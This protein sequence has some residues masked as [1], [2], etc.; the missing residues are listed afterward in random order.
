MKREYNRNASVLKSVLAG[1][2]CAVALGLA[3]AAM[4]QT[5]DFNV[6]AGDLK[7]AL[8][9]YARQAG[10]E[11]VYRT[12]DVRGARSR[13]AHGALV[14]T[15]ALADI[16]AGTGLEIRQEPGGA[17]A[18]V[19]AGASDPKSQGPEADQAQG[20][21][22]VVV[23]GTRIKG[24]QPSSPTV[25]LSQETIRDQGL[26]S[27]ADAIRALPQNFSGG[28]NPGVALGAGGINNQNLTGSSAINLRG[29][30]PDATL[31]LLNGRRLS[32]DAFTQAVDV[33]VIPLAAIDQ[34]QVVTDGASAIYGSDAVAGVAN[35]ILKRDYDGVDLS[36]RYGGATD[37]GDVQT[38]YSLTAGHTWSTGGFIVAYNYEHDTAIY[39]DQRDY[40]SYMPAPSN[41]MPT[42]N[43]QS[44]LA[45]GHQDLSPWI[46]LSVD[47]LYSDRND[48]QVVTE[49]P[50]RIVYTTHTTEYLVS[51]TLSFDLPRRWTLSVNGLY[52]QESSD[53]DE[54]TY[55]LAGNLLRPSA[56]CYC[57]AIKQIEADAEGPL[58]ALP[59]GE[60]RLALGGGYR[61]NSFDQR[62]FTSTSHTNGDRHSYYLFGELNAPLV[63][64]GQDVPL[65]RR[66]SVNG[67]V[68]YESYDDIGDVA[69]PKLGA[70]WAPVDD[71]ELKVSW[72]K[73]F[74]APTLLQQHQAAYAELF[75]AVVFGGSPPP[76]TTGLLIGGGNTD[77]K[78]E[79]ATTF[80][81]G[82]TWRPR[83]APGLKL[84]ASYFHLNYKDRVVEPIDQLGRTL[85]DP[86]LAQFVTL[87][88]SPALQ[89]Q[90]LAGVGSFYNF[91]GVYDPN[92]VYALVNDAYTNVAREELD[93]VD[94]NGDYTR[95][96]AG[97]DISLTGTA[98]WLHATKVVAPGEAPVAISGVVFE[99]PHFRMRAGLT[100]TRDGLTLSGFVNHQS[101]LANNVVPPYDEV[102]GQTTVDL[103]AL[104]RTGERRGLARDVTVALS[105][106][107]LFNKAPSYL[108][109]LAAFVVDYD[110]TNYS[111]VGRFISLTI[112]K[113]W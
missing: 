79:R 105:V 70:I 51:P 73:S 54:P 72:G 50:Q 76:G 75:P 96:F 84:E 83:F 78:P 6:P 108:A 92:V 12:E 47:A 43:Q 1:G 21:E 90:A 37:G 38:Q 3:G 107:N 52:G 82:F 112:T 58:M 25:V 17:L 65:V 35:V 101:S 81:T 97:G 110:S 56:G 10:V 106:Q 2:A 27:V 46:H 14:P 99:P 18:V 16:L 60:A 24:V 69:T 32:Y 91:V 68:R 77:L 74:K 88:P 41:L 53:Y 87:N 113:H 109:P 59:G 40:T 86:A 62:S 104:Y 45:S 36:A 39:S 63:G 44:V 64:P 42:V 57:N 30:G 94:L 20:V 19:R 29:L 34:I 80:T 7:A 4:A 13:G 15:Q 23:T 85:V 98:S 49:P 61:V 103:A 31:T 111:P 67:A 95:P 9:A 33:S 26:S 11:L 71:L 22:E 89:A 28:Q 93:G 48:R 102:E 8:D 66:L 55:D 5:R 100:W